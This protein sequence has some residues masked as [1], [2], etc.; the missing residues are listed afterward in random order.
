[1]EWP[2][3]L[4]DWHK[5]KVRIITEAQPS[6]EDILS[7]VNKPWCEH[8]GCKCRQVVQSLRGVGYKGD[9]PMIDG[10]IFFIGREYDGPHRAALNVYVGLSKARASGSAMTCRSKCMK[11]ACCTLCWS[12]CSRRA[13]AAGYRHD[14]EPVCTQSTPTVVCAKH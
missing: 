7:N 11:C 4:K 9:L 3:F 8:K 1:M 10:H 13:K 5:N 6:L 12:D 2:T 14:R